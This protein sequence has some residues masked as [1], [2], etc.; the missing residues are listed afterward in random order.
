MQCV[1]KI[2][3]IVTVSCVPRV[4]VTPEEFIVTTNPAWQRHL[5]IS[6]TIVI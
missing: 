2:A 4:R 3:L 1:S 5:S 6:G